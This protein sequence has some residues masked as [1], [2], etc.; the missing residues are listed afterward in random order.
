M[1]A[2]EIRKQFSELPYDKKRKIT[3]NLAERIIHKANESGIALD[4]SILNL[5]LTLRRLNSGAIS[6]DDFVEIREGTLEHIKE[7]ASDKSKQGRF[8]YALYCL[9]FSS[10]LASYD[11]YFSGVLANKADRNMVWNDRLVG[12]IMGL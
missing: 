3:T 6:E 11:V 7:L 8:A 1:T 9:S 10:N 5:V 2:E 4:N 12:I